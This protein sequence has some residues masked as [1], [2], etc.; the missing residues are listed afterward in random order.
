M[1]EARPASS[2]ATR[3]EFLVVGWGFPLSLTWELAQSSLYLDHANGW[4]YIAWTRLHC[5]VGDVLIL[6]AAFWATAA[7]CR[8]WHWPAKFGWGASALFV[9]FGLAYTVWS[10]WFN[11]TVRDSWAY[12]AEMPTVGGI[13]VSPL[14]QWLVIPIFLLWTLKSGKTLVPRTAEV[15]PGNT[16]EEGQRLEGPTE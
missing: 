8:S 14:A 12:T 3:G 7:V 16:S 15:A 11:T 9:G 13:G 4:R 5:T 2:V 1:A 10:E 6:L